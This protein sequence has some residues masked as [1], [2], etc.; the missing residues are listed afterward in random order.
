M[1]RCGVRCYARRNVHPNVFL[2]VVRRSESQESEGTLGRTTWEG[3][4][5]DRRS[6][7]AWTLSG[8]AANVKG[9]RRE[10]GKQEMGYSPEGAGGREY[11]LPSELL[12]GGCTLLFIVC[13][14]QGGDASAALP[15]EDD[16]RQ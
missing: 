10:D 4:A 5:S 13:I 12:V 15:L 3:E 6:G 16:S 14:M 8:V 11:G 7:W 9:E 1:V 2:L